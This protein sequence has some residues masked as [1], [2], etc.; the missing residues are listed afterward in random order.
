MPE[1]TLEKQRAKLQ[2][3]EKGFFA[4]HLMKIGIDLGIFKKL[5]SSNKGMSSRA[6]SSELGLHEPYVTFWCKTAY[7]LE[8]L[9]YDEKGKFKLAPHMDTL[10]ADNESF[11]YFGP[12]INMRVR[13][14]AEHLRMFP[15]C[16]KSGGTLTPEVYSD[17]FSKAQKAMSD[18][19][20]PAGYMFM[21]IPSVEGLRERLDAGIRILDVG[22]GSGILMVQLAKAFPKCEFVGVEV[23]RFAVEDARKHIRD[24]G[25]QGRVAAFYIDADGMD[26]DRE[27]DLVNLSLVLHEIG[28]DKR[29]SS[30]A[31]SYVALKHS[32]EI[33][34]LDFAY[35][36][37][38]QDL[39]KPQYSAGILDQFN[40]LTRGSEILPTTAKHR[41]LLELGFKDPATVS[42]LGG[43]FEVTHARK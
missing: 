34:I 36:E 21:L 24:S 4:I 19:A 22:C 42:L 9:D 41:L 5:N 25:V 15:Q 14:S 7:H 11:Y 20:I 13:H 3:Y 16:F 27:F 30:M 2:G 29:R 39:R 26:Y 31:K 6:L 38:L 1:I 37:K 28:R 17:D 8:I 43:S 12:T 35:P 40:E 10:L 33:V 32:G 18:Q 23:D